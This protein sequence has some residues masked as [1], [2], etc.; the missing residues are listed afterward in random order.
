MSLVTATSFQHSP[1]IQSRTFAVIGVLATGDVDDDLLYQMLVA[2]KQGLSQSDET[3]TLAVVTMLRCVTQVV[4]VLP[5][6]SRYLAQLFWLGFA[7]VQASA[8]A[9]YVEATRLMQQ[10]LETMDR[11]GAFV[12]QPVSTVLLEA[13]KSLHDIAEQLDM[14][15]KLEFRANFAFALVAPI[16]KGLHVKTL[17]GSADSLLRC[18]LKVT[19]SAESADPAAAEVGA[20]PPVHPNVLA[21]FLALLSTCSTQERYRQLLLDARVAPAWAAEAGTRTVPHVPLDLLGPLEQDDVLL[22]TTFLSVMLSSAQ[23]D[24]EESEI[25]YTLLAEIAE[26]HPD[27]I[28]L[29]YVIYVCLLVAH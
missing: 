7:L 20:E 23:G 6:D 22:V 9:F 2:F 19:A 27:Q 11:H 5:P 21:Y 26:Y 25:V 10:C 16:F 3:R 17:Q 1:C 15:L 24:D 8:I 4:P 28:V 29:A 13:R 14:V 18:L 12:H